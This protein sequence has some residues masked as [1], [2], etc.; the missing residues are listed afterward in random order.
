MTGV[1]DVVM[2]SDA[3]LSSE[4]GFDITITVGIINSSIQK[5][6]AF[7]HFVS[8]RLSNKDS[9]AQSSHGWGYGP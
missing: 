7:S 2:D 4:I 1:F 9:E 5:N 3:T 8:Y 6:L